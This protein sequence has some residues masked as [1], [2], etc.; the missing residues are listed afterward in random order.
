MSYVSFNPTQNNN[1]PSLT[2]EINDFGKSVLKASQFKRFNEILT[3]FEEDSQI[4]NNEQT[5]NVLINMCYSAEPYYKFP[6]L[7]TIFEK[8]LVD[9]KKIGTKI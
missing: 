9:Q 5:L 3:R 6:N 1:K 7:S 8:I 2:E 4:L